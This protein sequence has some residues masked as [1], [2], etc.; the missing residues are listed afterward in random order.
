MRNYVTIEKLKPNYVYRIRARN[1]NY[2]IWVPQCEGFLISRHKMGR[3]FLFIEH[4]CDCPEWATAKPIGEICESKFRVVDWMTSTKSFSAWF[5][6][7]RA[8]KTLL[9]Y[10]NRMDR[11]LGGERK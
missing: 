10:L 5:F 3:N 8:R 7:H 2:G 4:H 11:T 1:A 9:S 6:N